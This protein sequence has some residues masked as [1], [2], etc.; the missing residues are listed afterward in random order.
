MGKVNCSRVILGGLLAGVVLIILGFA[1]YSIYLEKPWSSALEALGH[2]MS[3]TS[4]G[5]VLAIVFSLVTGI[6]AVW[7]YAAIRPR[8]GAGPKTAVTAGGIFW[9]IGTLFPAI[10]FGSMGLFPS[11]LLVIDTLTSLVTLVVAT[12]AGAWVYKEEA[13]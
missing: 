7:L 2:P 12:L 11:R 4:W 3:V 10:S 9:I 6:L 5:Y 13:K 1:A 8:Y